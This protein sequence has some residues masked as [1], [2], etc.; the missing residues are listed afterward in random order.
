MS[1]TSY[2]YQKNNHSRLLT[3]DERSTFPHPNEA[4]RSVSTFDK[5]QAAKSSLPVS[6]NADIRH[7]ASSRMAQAVSTTIFPQPRMTY[8]ISKAKLDRPPLPE[9][10]KQF[11]G[12][13]R[14][15]PNKGFVATR[16]RHIAR[17]T[18]ERFDSPAYL[19]KVRNEQVSPHSYDVSD[20]HSL[21]AKG[22][23]P[24]HYRGKF[25]REEV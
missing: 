16:N 5:S 13:T 17:N 8:S 24:Q 21:G 15:S 12:P 6:L 3:L 14:Y 2:A 9:V 20:F 4:G 7:T 19:S 25:T 11:I 18:A 23:S 22:R 1:Q 10:Q